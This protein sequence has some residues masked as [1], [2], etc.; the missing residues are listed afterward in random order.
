MV[1]EKFS[2]GSMILAFLMGLGLFATLS[3]INS[4]LDD[5]HKLLII[6]IDPD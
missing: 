5:L 1:R 4:T 6:K 2:L 3:K